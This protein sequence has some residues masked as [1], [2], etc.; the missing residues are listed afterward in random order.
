MRPSLEKHLKF[1]LNP[2]SY[3]S[4]TSERKLFLVENTFKSLAEISLLHSEVSTDKWEPK[5]SKI[6]KGF[7]ENDVPLFLAL[8]KHSF[9]S[10]SIENF[11][12]TRLFLFSHKLYF[13]GPSVFS[14]SVTQL[15]LPV[16]FLRSYNLL[17]FFFWKT[18]NKIF[19]KRSH[20]T[21]KIQSYLI[22]KNNLFSTS[23][24]IPFFSTFISF[25]CFDLRRA[26]K[27]KQF[28]A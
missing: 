21:E 27:S 4:K 19:S 14:A 1:V 13:L 16:L 10:Q 15:F 23:L 26:S 24:I 22:S 9:T 18:S 12:T 7:N 25:F 20:W 3:H 5:V 28:E 2:K 6:R 11:Q 17:S 8:K